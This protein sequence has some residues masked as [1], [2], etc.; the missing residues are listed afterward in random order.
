MSFG[1]IKTGI[2]VDSSFFIERNPI[3]VNLYSSGT[4]APHGVTNR[5]TYTVPVKKFA[6]LKNAVAHQMIRTAATTAVTSGTYIT[7]TTGGNAFYV[8]FTRLGEDKNTIGNSVMQMSS[9]EILLNAGDTVDIDTDN[10]STDG[11]IKHVGSVIITQYN[12]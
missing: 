6:I 7:L 4:Y 5:K 8:C 1:S 9:N 2:L 11:T 12:L 10:I 3:S